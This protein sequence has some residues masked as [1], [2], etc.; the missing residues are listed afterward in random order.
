MLSYNINSMY[1]K[2]EGRHVP[3]YISIYSDRSVC[4]LKLQLGNRG[5]KL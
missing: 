2:Y 1:Q 3:S 5:S 4:N